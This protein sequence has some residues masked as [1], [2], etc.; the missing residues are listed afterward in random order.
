MWELVVSL[1]DSSGNLD[2]T[3]EVETTTGARRDND[4]DQASQADWQLIQT[5]YD[6]QGRLD[7]QH[8]NY[9]NRTLIANDWDAAGQNDWS[10][11]TTGYD[12]Q[13]LLD[14]QRENRDNGS[15]VIRDWDQANLFSWSSKAF[16][17]NA[18]GMIDYTWEYLDS[19]ARI[20]VDY[21]AAN[22]YNWSARAT[23]INNSGA[24]TSIREIL[25]Q[26]ASLVQA[27]NV[28]WSVN[29]EGRL[30][31]A[32]VQV[33]PSSGPNPVPAVDPLAPTT[34]PYNLT[35]SQPPPFTATEVLPPSLTPGGP[36]GAG[37]YF[38]TNEYG[39]WELRGSFSLD[40]LQGFDDAVNDLVDGIRSSWNGFEDNVLR[41]IERVVEDVFRPITRI[42]GW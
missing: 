32:G 34:D 30:Q 39:E 18:A 13:G 10:L 22:Q 23:H 35:G 24:T 15:Y 28:R 1:Y 41:P 26:V 6:A 37:V 11:I 7:W 21:D 14:W 17:F 31:I 33:L 9:D 12:A 3:Q 16:Q 2:F 4:Y 5:L 25:D 27:V 38:V 42:F 36:G 40:D 29:S 8:V 20:E 19:R